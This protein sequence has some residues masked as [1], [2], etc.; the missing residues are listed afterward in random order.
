MH[1]R[2]GIRWSP[3]AVVDK[4]DAEQTRWLQSRVGQRIPLQ[5]RHFLDAGLRPFEQAESIGNLLTTAGLTRLMS[6]LIAGGG[7][8]ATNTATRLGT[9][10]GAGSAAIGDTDLGASAGSSNRWFQTMDATYPSVAASVMTAKATFASA[11]G[12]YAWNEWGLDIGTPTVSSGATVNA[13]LLNHKT[14]AALGTKVAGQTWALTVT[15][16]IS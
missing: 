6:L 1:A 3:V 16:T 8:G 10:N 14:S 12:N 7:Q 15:I 13:T 9:G 11:D 5:H 2:E 4:F